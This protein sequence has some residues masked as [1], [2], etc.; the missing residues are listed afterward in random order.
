MTSHDEVWTAKYRYDSAF[1][2]DT[3]GEDDADWSDVG[4]G[5]HEHDHHWLHDDLLQVHV[6][7]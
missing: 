6:C 3:K 1:H 2:P 4:S 5:A 7:A